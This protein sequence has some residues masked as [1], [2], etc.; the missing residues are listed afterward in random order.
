MAMYKTCPFCGDNLDPS[1][2]CEC[3]EQEDRRSEQDNLRRIRIGKRY[4]C[5]R[6]SGVSICAGKMSARYASGSAGF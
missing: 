3:Q 6:G 2:K 4:G 1:E 5:G